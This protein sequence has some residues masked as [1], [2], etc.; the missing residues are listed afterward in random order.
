MRHL[1]LVRIT[2]TTLRKPID[3]ALLGQDWSYLTCCSIWRWWVLLDHV[4]R[5]SLQDV[6]VI[7]TRASFRHK[8][9]LIQLPYSCIILTHWLPSLNLNPWNRFTLSTLQKWI[10]LGLNI[11]LGLQFHVNLRIG[12]CSRVNHKVGRGFA[13]LFTSR[14]DIIIASCPRSW[15]GSPNFVLLLL[16]DLLFFCSWHSLLN[17]TFG[18]LIG[19]VEIFEDSVIWSEI[20]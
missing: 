6:G 9:W 11:S 15:H 17:F 19:L 13:K 14:L 1:R 5:L 2:I 7:E 4:C 8:P 3:R 10:S 16:S 12:C 20:F 18:L